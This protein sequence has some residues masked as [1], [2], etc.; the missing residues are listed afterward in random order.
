MTASADP[1]PELAASAPAGARI[2]DFFIVGHAKC[3]TTA[4]YEALR[5]HPDIF[6]PRLKEPWYFARSNPHPQAG[7]EGSIAYTGRKRETLQEY[8][9]NF[10]E[11]R[12]DQLIGEG[13]TSYLWSKTAAAS[14]PRS[15][16]RCTSSG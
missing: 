7:G 14:P 15:C 10:T 6:M 13:S 2:P 5:R 1:A 11:A 4:L 3:G 9:A 12:P 8:L 16:A